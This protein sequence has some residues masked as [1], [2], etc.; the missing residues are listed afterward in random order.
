[1]KRLKGDSEFRTYNLGVFDS[2]THLKENEFIIEIKHEP[3]R[4]DLILKNKSSHIPRSSIQK[5]DVIM[6]CYSGA[7]KEYLYGAIQSKK[8][9]SRSRKHYISHLRWHPLDYPNINRKKGKR[10]SLFELS[11][12]KIKKFITGSLLP[13][14]NLL[15]CT[16]STSQFLDELY[17][18]KSGR[19]HWK[20]TNPI[21]EPIL[22]YSTKEPKPLY[23]LIQLYEYNATGSVERMVPKIYKVGSFEDCMKEAS[24]IEGVPNCF[25]I[26]G[27]GCFEQW[28]NSSLA[29]RGMSSLN[30]E[31]IIIPF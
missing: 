6:A 3:R 28:L 7:Q 1:M 15:A 11:G 4:Y 14:K 21:N 16:P 31:H 29:D 24:A 23:E 8:L 5:S 20:G 22:E 19:L 18:D 27:E 26:V 17:L 25:I 2:E 12:F 10:N 30:P 9:H 13:N